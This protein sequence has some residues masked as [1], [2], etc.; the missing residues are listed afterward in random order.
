MDPHD[1][2]LRDQWVLLHAATVVAVR[3]PLRPASTESMFGAQPVDEPP[4]RLGQA[5]VRGDEIRPGGVAAPPLGDLTGP[6]QRHRRRVDDRGDVGVPLIVVAV[7]LTAETLFVLSAVHG[8]D[9]RE[10]F[11]RFVVVRVRRGHGA[12]VAGERDVLCVVDLLIAEEQ[13]LVLVQ[14]GA[15]L[16]GDVVRERVSQIES[17]HIGA[18]V[19]GD[20]GG[21]RE[22]ACDATGASD[23]SVMGIPHL[24]RRS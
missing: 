13:H 22:R 4:Q 9:L 19:T 11:G 5:V 18:D 21:D 14:S 1:R 2:M 23:A 16:L 3:G 6:Q 10:T 24:W 8:E 17:A 7:L 20:R 15:Q 12:E